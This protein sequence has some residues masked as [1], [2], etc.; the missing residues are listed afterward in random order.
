MKPRVYTEQNIR[1]AF[2]A[3][4]SSSL[5]ADMMEKTKE[6]N[7]RSGK[8]LPVAPKNVC[9]LVFLVVRFRYYF[10]LIVFFHNLPCYSFPTLSI[11]AKQI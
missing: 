3:H 5:Q 9:V 2:F 10:M 8:A 7:T 11:K 4:N 6:F 1:Q